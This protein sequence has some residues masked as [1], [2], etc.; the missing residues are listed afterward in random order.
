MQMRKA[1][2]DQG[3]KGVPCSR[4]DWERMHA[5]ELFLRKMCRFL[6]SNIQIDAGRESCL[7][8][9]MG[10]VLKHVSVMCR[11]ASLNRGEAAGAH[12][13]GLAIALSQPSDP[14]S[15]DAAA[16]MRLPQGGLQ[17]TIP[18]VPPSLEDRL[19]A[20]GGYPGEAPPAMV[21]PGG[22]PGAMP[23]SAQQHAA[24]SQILSPGSAA[25]SMSSLG[26][27]D[28]TA[29]LRQMWQ[30]VAGFD[31]PQHQ[32]RAPPCACISSS[33]HMLYSLRIHSF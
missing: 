22:G 10:V 24:L 3:P 2:K 33:L 21:P 12:S 20:A 16:A 19:R 8:Q 11:L 27:H 1:V 32:A 25:T 7:G 14:Y 18:G 9:L 5:R 13:V 6:C 4:Q 30:A 31:P 26:T 23:L 15:I 17:Y 29:N 28:S